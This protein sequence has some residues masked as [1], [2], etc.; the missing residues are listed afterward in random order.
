MTRRPWQR[1]T[2]GR[3]A[4]SVDERKVDDWIAYGGECVALLGA[5]AVHFPEFLDVAMMLPELAR[6]VWR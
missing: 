6:R 2:D 5:D 1:L 4:V 3:H